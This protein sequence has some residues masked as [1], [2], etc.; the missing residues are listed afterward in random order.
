MF[1]SKQQKRVDEIIRER[2]ARPKTYTV[3]QM[4]W[5]YAIW[6]GDKLVGAKNIL[7]QT[8]EMFY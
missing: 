8:I 7:G 6:A 2:N 5:R 1:T 3:E 4:S